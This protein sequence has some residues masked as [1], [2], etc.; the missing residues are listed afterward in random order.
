MN[1]RDWWKRDSVSTF[2]KHCFTLLL[3]FF[4][5][6]LAKGALSLFGFSTNLSNLF[7]Y[8][9]FAFTWLLGLAFFEAYRNLHLSINR[10]FLIS[11]AP[12]FLVVFIS[13]SYFF[14]YYE[15]N[16]KT[17]YVLGWTIAENCD[18]R[19]PVNKSTYEEILNHCGAWDYTPDFFPSYYI[20][21]YILAFLLA[22]SF[23]S[24]VFTFF[25]YPWRR[26]RSD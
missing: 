26:Q 2:Y 4:L 14:S 3:S 21:Q 19:G 18:Y 25:A 8:L 16:Y 24:S 11:V 22:G 1:F 23:A 6:L 7:W 10:H 15:N 20:L 9:T 5:H 13:V 12:L 17:V